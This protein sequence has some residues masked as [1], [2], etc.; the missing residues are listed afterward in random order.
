M[1]KFI[2]KKMIIL[3]LKH[4]IN[5]SETKEEKM[6]EKMEEKR[7][8]THPVGHVAYLLVL[9]ELLDTDGFN[10][11]QFVGTTVFSPLPFVMSY[12]FQITYKKSMEQ[13]TRSSIPLNEKPNIYLF[14][15][16]LHSLGEIKS[17]INASIYHCTCIHEVSFEE[18]IIISL[19]DHFADLMLKYNI[20]PISGELRDPV[21]AFE[22]FKKFINRFPT[23]YVHNMIQKLEK[24]NYIGARHLDEYIE[25]M[26]ISK[27]DRISILYMYFSLLEYFFGETINGPILTDI[28]NYMV[29]IKQGVS[30][31]FK[32]R[33][34]SYL[35]WIA[36][37]R[38]THIEPEPEPEPEF[39]PEPEPEPE[40]KFEKYLDYEGLDRL[41]SCN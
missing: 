19:F 10:P 4:K 33:L 2:K 22:T 38:A 11:A 12:D 1:E 5:S 18:T 8:H 13:Y 41:F 31:N 9:P 39:E 28:G 40:F 15:S 3:I 26:D 16:C 32:N 25:Q 34:L 7:V 27:K 35:F 21:E 6:E 14:V 17:P 36:L 29:F 37:S 23:S 20:L 30:P 24:N